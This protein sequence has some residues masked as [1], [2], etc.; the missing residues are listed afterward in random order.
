[1]QHTHMSSE[2]VIHL[3]LEPAL[4][5]RV[6]SQKV[7]G[8]GQRVAAGFI[9]RQEENKSLTH[10]LVL[11]HGPSLMTPCGCLLGLVSLVSE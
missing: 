11:R 5:F 6:K 4:T 7:T 3:L 1:M 8:E 10:N 2:E 9:A